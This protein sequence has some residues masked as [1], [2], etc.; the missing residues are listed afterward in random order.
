M[1]RKSRR[2]LFRSFRNQA[3]WTRPHWLVPPKKTT[4]YP[5]KPQPSKKP[6][7]SDQMIQ[8]QQAGNSED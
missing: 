4:V 3:S 8:D 7:A 2:N 1:Y 5:G 6:G